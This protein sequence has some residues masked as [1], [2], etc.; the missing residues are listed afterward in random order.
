MQRD[1]AVA[2]IQRGLAFR[3]DL[4]NEIVD[5]LK[6][7]QRKRE[8]GKTPPWFL[9]NE[10]QPLSITAATINLPVDFWRTG[11]K[12]KIKVTIPGSV[13]PAM[14]PRYDLDDA[15]ALFGA[16]GSGAP[17]NAYVLR[18]LTLRFFPAPNTTYSAVWSYYKHDQVLDTNIENLW[19]KYAPDLL[20]GDAGM[21]IASDLRDQAAVAIFQGLQATGEREAFVETVLRELDDYPLHM[22]EQL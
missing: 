13:L 9:L 12:E 7:A 15:I 17:V 14:I 1:T 6:E 11:R 8:A 4:S 3:T 5:A 20:I 2:R 16:L 21:I 22:G 19:L 10:D 18:T